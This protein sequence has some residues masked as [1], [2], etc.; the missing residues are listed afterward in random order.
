MGFRP[1]VSLF[2]ERKQV[3]HVHADILFF[4]LVAAFLIYRLN[5]VLGT[6][7]GAERERPNPFARPDAP[8]A[9]ALPPHTPQPKADPA[10]QLAG[11]EAVVD[12]KAN[13]D[14][15]I[16]TG[17]QEIAGADARFEL[18]TFM[19]GAKAAFAM[20]VQAY[21]KGDLA[22]LKPLLS[23]KLYGDFANG[24]A[25]RQEAG[26]T[27]ETIIHR[28]KAARITEAH[29]GG[30]MA[31][32]TVRYTVEET[33]FTRDRAGAVISGSPDRIVDVEDVWTFMRDTRSK[34][35]NWT[36]IETQAEEKIS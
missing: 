12:T 36:L 27:A 1:G 19:T 35:P 11:A 6:R 26:E 4:A 7:T 16:D 31:Y 17:L 24:I 30:A 10:R 28:I 18:S 25:K 3:R 32:A 13:A 33:A 29:L 5:A 34:D 8:R 14:G 20:I 9:P 21:N 2:E 15:R 23:P 22:A